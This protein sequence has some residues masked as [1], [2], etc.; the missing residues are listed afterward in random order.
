MLEDENP[1]WRFLNYG[2]VPQLAEILGQKIVEPWDM[3]KDGKSLLHFAVEY[4][5]PD[6]CKYLLE[7]GMDKHFQD[8]SGC[9]AAMMALEMVIPSSVHP[10]KIIEGHELRGLFRDDSVAEVMNSSPLHLAIL[11]NEDDDISMASKIG[12]IRFKNDQDGFGR[13]PLLWAAALNRPG[14]AIELLLNYGAD[15]SSVDK[16]NKT[17]LHW[18]MVSQAKEV[19]RTLLKSGASLEARDCFG[20]TPLHE[21]AKIPSST[22]LIKMLVENGAVVDARDDIYERTPLHLAAYHGRPENILALLANGANIDARARP[23]GRTPL[24]MAISY[25]R[26]DSVKMLL[27][28][29]ADAATVD[30]EGKSVLHLAARYS[31]VGIMKALKQTIDEM[32]ENVLSSPDLNQADCEGNTGEDYFFSYRKEYYHGE[33]AEEKEEKAAFEDLVIA[34]RGIEMPTFYDCSED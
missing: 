31:S 14:T 15:H 33:A 16:H 6:I 4:R 19:A 34:A 30:D 27:K 18:A 7:E 28:Q 8:F 22:G 20:R 25:N 32:A 17:A 24:L 10:D 5:R 1:V 3:N 11:N 29:G 13:T 9:T 12:L 2:T 23:N 21:T 26:L